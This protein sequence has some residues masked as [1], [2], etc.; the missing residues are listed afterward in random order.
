MII[1]ISPDKGKTDCSEVL[2]THMAGLEYHAC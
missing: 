2:I 1:I